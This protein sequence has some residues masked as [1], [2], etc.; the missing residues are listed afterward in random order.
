MEKGVTKGGR[1][2]HILVDLLERKAGHKDARKLEND[3]QKVK[4]WEDTQH[5]MV[6]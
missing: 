5:H 1:R 4:R 3:V 6:Q 2:K